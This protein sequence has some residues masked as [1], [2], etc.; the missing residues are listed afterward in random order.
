MKRETQVK[1]MKHVY[2]VIGVLLG[3]VSLMFALDAAGTIESHRPTTSIWIPIVWSILTASASLACYTVSREGKRKKIKLKRNIELQIEKESCIG[4]AI[5]R[6]VSDYTYRKRT[7]IGLLFLC[8]HIEL[9]IHKKFV[10]GD[11]NLKAQTL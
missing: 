11:I 10:D 4:F 8:W 3:V 2:F 5:G 9:V 6:S 7:T 1:I